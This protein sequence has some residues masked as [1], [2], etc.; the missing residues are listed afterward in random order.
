MEIPNSQS[1]YRI[2]IMAMEVK[3]KVIQVLT[4]QT[5]QGKKGTWRKQEFILE[6]QSQYPKKV[7]LSLWGDKI[8]QF[9]VSAGDTVTASVELESREYNSRWY[10]EAR[11]WKIVKESSGQSF[12]GIDA[13]QDTGGSNLNQGTSTDDLP[14]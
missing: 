3:G 11:A 6:T 8:D 13:A 12:D 7:C 9:K 10:T 5:G 14:F 2:T 4:P 1:N